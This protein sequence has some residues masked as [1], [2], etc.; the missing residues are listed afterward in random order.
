MIEE[1]K[2]DVRRTIEAAAEFALASPEPQE[3]AL[4]ADVYAPQD[5]RAV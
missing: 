4:F 1:I 2:K 3:A 5:G